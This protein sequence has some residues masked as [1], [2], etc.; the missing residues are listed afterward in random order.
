MDAIETK[1]RK[2]GD[3][4]DVARPD[5][6]AR[7]RTLQAL[8]VPIKAEQ[9]RTILVAAGVESDTLYDTI[10]AEANADPATRKLFVREL[11]WETTT[12][13]LMEV[14]AVY[15]EIEEGAVIMDKV[16]GKSKGFAFITFKNITSANAALAEP[17][18]N[19]GGRTCQCNLAALGPQRAA[20][21]DVALG[22]FPA[23]VGT[24]GLTKSHSGGHM[25]GNNVDQRKLFVRGISWD[26]TTEM[27]LKAFGEFGEIE[28]GAVCMDRNTGK[29]RGFAFVTFAT[30]AGANAALVEEAKNIDGRTTHCNL[31]A[32]GKARL[33][34]QQQPPQ[35]QQQYASYGYNQYNAQQQ[36]GQQ[37]GYYGQP[38]HGGYQMAQQQQMMGMYG[39]PPATH[40]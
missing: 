38:Q 15:G 1:K 3:N 12:E 34:A 9:L 23:R 14:F 17:S 25:V 39:Q 27:L 4:F 16:T 22:G 33:Q 35:M 7:K 10:L 5:A 36:Y 2:I 31:A 37:G 32:K 24:N 6:D 21:S 18:K 8:L 26:T 13:E 28:E 40:Q 29:S 20:T 11:A 30:V 19:I